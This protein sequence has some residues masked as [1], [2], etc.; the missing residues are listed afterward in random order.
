MKTGFR[1]ALAAFVLLFL[2]TASP[3][4]ASEVMTYAIADHLSYEFYQGWYA[5]DVAWWIHWDSSTNNINRSVWAQPYSWLAPKLSSAREGSPPAA[6]P[7]YIVLNWDQGPVFTTAPGQPAYSGLWQVFYVTWKPGFGRPITN[8]DPASLSNPDGMPPAAE[9]DVVSTDIVVQYPIIALGQLDGPWY[10]ATPG[11]YRMKQVVAMPD[12]VKTKFIWLPTHRVFC[13]D[14]VTNRVYTAVVTVPDVGDAE[15][16]EELGANLA[17]GLNNV[18]LSDTQK[19]WVME[20]PKPLSQ[21]PIMEHCP[22]YMGSGNTNREFSPIAQI[23]ALQ[24]NIPYYAVINNPG[25]V[26]YLIGSG[27]LVVVRTDQRAGLLFFFGMNA[28]AVKY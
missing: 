17:P 23:V 19:L 28:A 24:R 20:D 8:A 14:H 7:V 25:F 10:P 2:T 13:K 12:Y 21:L 6:V 26:E 15:L 18:P 11:R 22:D 5:G 4:T 16:A 27:G 3:C 9:A 1:L